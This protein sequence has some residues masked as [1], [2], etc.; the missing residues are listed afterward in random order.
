MSADKHDNSSGLSRLNARLE[1]LFQE[2]PLVF[3][4]IALGLGLLLFAL[5]RLVEWGLR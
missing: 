3:N 4:L 1:K 5:S 2:H